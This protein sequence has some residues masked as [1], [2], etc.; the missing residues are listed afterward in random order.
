MHLAELFPRLLRC[1][2]LVVVR[3]DSAFCNQKVFDA[4]EAHE[5]CFAVVSPMQPNFE[6]LAEAI[7][8]SA[9]KPY[10]GPGE[11]ALRAR[12]ST[13]LRKRHP[14][15]RRR[16]ARRRGKHDL[17]L[18]RQWI[19]EIPYRPQRSAT[20]YRLVIRRQRIEK[21]YQGDSSSSGAT[22]TC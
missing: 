15:L 3:G 11:R 6:A 5:Q 20:T 8:E 7:P 12:P 2:R 21:H 10:R 19:A 9:W 1:F 17:R 18:E 22:A 13:R 14:K 4:C 16:L